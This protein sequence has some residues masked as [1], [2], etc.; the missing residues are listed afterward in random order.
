MPDLPDLP[1]M[2]GAPSTPPTVRSL[3][4]LAEHVLGAGLHAATGHIGLQVAPGGFATP[5]S[6]MSELGARWTVADGA[7]A[8]T[9]PDGSRQ[10]AP[11]TTVR[12]AADFFGI[13]PGMP[14]SVY[15][16]ATEL[17]L[18]A[19]LVIDDAVAEKI[20]G[21]LAL[22][23]EALDRFASAHADAEPSGRTLWPE[24]FDLGLAMAEVNYGVSPGDADHAEPYLYVGPWTP[25]SGSFWNE[26]FGA[27]VTASTIASVADAVAFFELGLAATAEP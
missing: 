14:S 23:D 21:W 27:S 1:E 5:E 18:D 22:G 7:L 2:S 8:I 6:A 17:D 11:I 4:V 3:H 16:P 20:A 12:A 13:V 10:Q 15:A 19:V 26:S 9:R 25:R 24:H